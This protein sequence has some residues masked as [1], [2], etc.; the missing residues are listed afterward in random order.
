[1]FSP[2]TSILQRNFFSETKGLRTTADGFAQ[3]H[4]DSMI[5][6]PPVRTHCRF[7]W[8]SLTKYIAN[9]AVLVHQFIVRGIMPRTVGVGR[10]RL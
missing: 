2:I 1:M 3:C 7:C 9:S 6:A 5:A 8:T 10:A 4:I